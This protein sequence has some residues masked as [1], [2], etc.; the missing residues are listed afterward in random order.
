MDFVLVCPE[1]R[2]Q[3][4]LAVGGGEVATRKSATGSR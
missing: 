3:P 2:E 4:C 1:I